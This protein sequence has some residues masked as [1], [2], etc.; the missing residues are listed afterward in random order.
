LRKPSPKQNQQRR[1]GGDLYTVTP[2]AAPDPVEKFFQPEWIRLP[3]SGR[4][5]PHSALS[6]SKINELILPSAL[7]N[8]RP[9]VRS[10][11][12]RRPGALRGSRLIHLQSLLEYIDQM[13]DAEAEKNRSGEEQSR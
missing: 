3:K 1:D 13:A 11:C 5:C 8:Y 2:V 12:L 7:N 10:A 9:P 4:L 6:R